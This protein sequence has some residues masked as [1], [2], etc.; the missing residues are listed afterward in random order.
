MKANFLCM[1]SSVAKFWC[2]MEF[3]FHYG[4]AAN[5]GELTSSYWYFLLR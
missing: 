5:L 3:A 2:S 4:K 1:L